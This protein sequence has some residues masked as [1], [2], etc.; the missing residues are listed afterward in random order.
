MQPI[1]ASIKT[2]EQPKS[3]I[4]NARQYWIEKFY[5]KLDDQRRINNFIRFQNWKGKRIP[6]KMIQKEEWQKFQKA[7]LP[8][9]KKY[10]KEFTPKFLGMKLAHVTTPD[11]H[12][13]YDDCMR[14]DD[15]K[16]GYNFSVCFFH[17]LKA[18]IKK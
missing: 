8:K 3:K 1:S 2:F 10:I 12:G 18:C 13:F 14:C 4:T 5:K 9:E 15:S 7:E 16:N 17:R 6:P 11:L